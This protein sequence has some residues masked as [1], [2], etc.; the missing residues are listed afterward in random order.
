MSFILSTRKKKIYRAVAAFLALNL[1]A[2]LVFPI[3]AH[4]LT[5]GP[6]QPEVQSFEPVGTSDMVDLFTGD[7]NY[8]IPLFELPGPNGGYP[9]NLAYHSGIGMDQ[10]ASWV[11][12]G[13]NLNPGAIVRNMRGLPDDFNGQTITRRTDMED[14][15]AFG[16]GYGLNSETAGADWEKVG[17]NFSAFFSLHYDN[18]KGLGYSLVPGF[19]FSHFIDQKELHKNNYGLDLTIDSK[20]GIGVGVKL[21]HSD[22][23]TRNM[24]SFGVGTSFSSRSGMSYSAFGQMRV[25]RSGASDTRRGGGGYSMGG[26]STFSFAQDAYTPVTSN[27]TTSVNLGISFKA[28]PVGAPLLFPNASTR[29]FYNIQHLDNKNQQ[30]N[31]FGYGYNYLGEAEYN[32]EN[33]AN[34]LD[35]RHIYD[36][37]REKDGMI[38]TNTPNLSTP[39]LTFDY[40]GVQGQGI[41]G[42]YRAYSPQAGRI[43]DSPVFSWGAGGSLG[44]E[45][46]GGGHFGFDA[47]LSYNSSHTSPWDDDNEWSDY[48]KFRQASEWDDNYADG[49]VAPEPIYYKSLGEMTSFSTTEMDYIG[50][51]YAV[52]ASMAEAGTLVS[53]K[54]VP[55]EEELIASNGALLNT[56]IEP[57][58]NYRARTARNTV[59]YP[60][61]NFDLC[62]NSNNP[63]LPEYNIDYYSSLPTALNDYPIAPSQALS[64]S[65]R[66]SMSIASHHAG[67]TAFNA[68]GNR[69]VYALPVYNLNHHEIAYSAPAQPYSSG[70]PATSFTTPSDG[71][72][73]CYSGNCGSEP[74]M[75]G[76]EEFF[77]ETN[78]GPYAH[79][80]LLTS[81]LGVDYV[82][83]TGD[84][85]TEDD[86]GYWVKFNY[87]KTYGESNSVNST[88]YKW[89]APYKDA[90]YEPGLFSTAKDDKGYIEYGEREV[91]YLA[92]VE[93]KTHVAE[94]VISSRN[95]GFAASGKYASGAGTDPSYKLDAIK[96]YS[97]TDY[98]KL[99][100]GNE[101]EA[102]PIKTVHFSYDYELCDNTLNTPTS[103]GGKLTLQEVWFEYQNNSRGELS[104]YQFNYGTSGNNPN[105]SI[106]NY[107][108]WSNYKS[109][110]DDFNRK[111]LPYTTQFDRSVNQ[112]VTNI[113]AFQTAKDIEQSV[114]N[115]REI[116]LPTGGKITVDYE[117]D[118]Y[119]YVQHRKATQMFNVTSFYDPSNPRWLYS[120]NTITGQSDWNTSNITKRRV[121]FKLEKPVEITGASTQDFFEQYIS[122]LKQ[123]D[124]SYQLYY[125]LFMDVRRDVEDPEEFIS[126]YAN[127]LTAVGGIDNQLSPDTAEYGFRNTS[128]SIDGIPCYTE[129]FVTVDLTHT[130][131][132]NTNEYHPFA[133]AAWQHLRTVQ[134]DLLHTPGYVFSQSPSSN[135]KVTAVMSLFSPLTDIKQMFQGFRDYCFKNNYGRTAADLDYCVIR[136]CT[137][138]QKKFGGGCRVKQLTI[139]DNWNTQS[140]ESNSEYGQVYTYTTTD[141]DGNT[142]SSGV[143]SYEPQIGGDEIALRHAKHYPQEIPIFTDNNLFF[144]YP[145]N[146]SN[147][148]APVVGY[149]KVTVKS[150][151]TKNVIAG[152]LPDAVRSTGAVVTEF[153]TAKDF[154]VITDE[155]AIDSRP[156]KLFIPIPFIGEIRTNNITAT[157]GYSIT[158][159]DMHGKLKSV[160]NYGMDTQ[161]NLLSEPESSVTYFYSADN[162]ETPEGIP[163]LELDN[164]VLVIYGDQVTASGKYETDTATATVGV[165]YDFFT[166]QRKNRNFSVSAGIDFNTEGLFPFPWPSFS[167]NTND[168][169][170]AVTNKIIH[171]TGIL[172]RVEAT[173][174]QSRVIT[175]NKVFD[176][177]TGR[178]LLVTVTNDYEA[179]IYRYDIPANWEY[180]NMGAAYKNIDFS[181]IADI[182]SVNG[183]WDNFKIDPS[184]ITWNTS[185]VTLS[186]DEVYNILAEGDEFILTYDDDD[187]GVFESAETKGRATLIERKEYCN[188]TT[189]VRTLLFHTPE[190]VAASHKVMLRVVRSGRRNLLGVNAGSIVALD[191]PTDNTLR[192]T[193]SLTGLSYNN[194][195]FAPE[196]AEFL[197]YTLDCS[198]YLVYKTYDL[199]ASTYYDSD[200]DHMFPTLSSVFSSITL[201]A[202]TGGFRI[203]FSYITPTGTCNEVDCGCFALTQVEGQ[204]IPITSFTYSS[205]ST[206]QA[207]HSGAAS[208]NITLECFS[209]SI[210]P[211][212]TYT[213]EVLNASAIRFRDFWDYDQEIGTCQSASVA[214]N[215]YAIGKKGIWRPWQDY[216]YSD[217]RYRNSGHTAGTQLA[218]DG[219]F[220][221]NGTDKK[222]YFFRWNATAWTPSPTQWVPNNTIT[223]FDKDGNELENRNIIG[224]FSCAKFGYENTLAVAVAANAR[225]FEVYYQS[226]EDADNPATLSGSGTNGNSTARAHTGATSI[227]INDGQSNKTHAIADNQF[228]ENKE[229][230]ISMWV[231]RAT[232]Q[233]TYKE[234]SSANSAAFTLTYTNM[235][236]TTISTSALFEPT[237]EVIEG[238]QRIEAHFT[239]PVNSTSG[240]DYVKIKINFQAGSVASSNVNTWFDDIRV[241]PADGNMVS[242]VY[243]PV[244]FRLAAKLDDNNYATFYH[245]DEEGSLFLVKQET[246]KGIAT[247]QEARS[248]KQHQ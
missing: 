77:S 238:W 4:A 233:Y 51:E 134:P 110:S 90:L 157:Q 235:A 89:R 218:T 171:K 195:S 31:Y 149:S 48:Y 69:Y 220:D 199:S 109:E 117:A 68:D 198:G 135:D 26:G 132:A 222:Y 99:G 231:A 137:P 128:T 108:R 150:L 246:A 129:G 33:V 203:I 32:Y 5:N 161:G 201:E 13:W 243:D 56:N 172:T 8:N 239:T 100:T 120:K 22:H 116:I 61:S 236:G 168:V 42:S 78:L 162:L 71:S 21:S 14:N 202:C 139:N 177:Q 240:E 126:G 103:T 88:S 112:T 192:G 94:F 119:A 83:L 70:L 86:N 136:L 219:V 204:N 27:T 101:S 28:G 34:K 12:L 193:E 241:F 228:S 125:K 36:M 144:E 226:V 205:G 65:T 102:R 217:E 57:N 127:V 189:P 154:P 29:G 17:V 197:N 15:H 24:R 164:N 64:R 176:A 130:D 30:V 92:T 40:Y 133:V 223:R 188:S 214:A 2:E 10:E 141:E 124:G 194:A 242:Y 3:A 212:V 43:Y 76:T 85:V 35:P 121:Y 113:A 75:N 115:L 234:S 138:D 187:D 73:P 147:Y 97:R 178:P 184:G 229:Y 152:T 190:N 145:L 248:H 215:L 174:G 96:V 67:V 247:I 191:N 153:Y 225:F 213:T 87:V 185:S 245:Y 169:R 98:A 237:G 183:T 230:V 227:L 81:I 165:E 93:T 181:F 111:Y 182:S 163:A 82:D 19:S 20:E 156:F 159:N 211:V 38:H 41:G 122:G 47:E 173:D 58:R 206:I 62:D 148:P 55:Q 151:T 158:L 140:G 39:N 105:Y 16:L 216:Y 118:D 196:L 207:N 7:F 107:D 160:T 66:S 52:R 175:E 104:P 170:T 1:I 179:P 44:V 142:I 186:F 49:S 60:I 63:L 59:V 95:D 25:N 208:N 80:Y 232:P 45:I 123:E 50:G 37:N 74:D 180:D 6:S 72:E 143:A 53:K 244:T 200:G 167:C 131:G 79:S 210:T 221:G 11:G 209:L 54:Y 114:W 46:G 166:D 224:N 23:V 84:G 146:E 9:F 155:T 18:Y 106:A 91:Y